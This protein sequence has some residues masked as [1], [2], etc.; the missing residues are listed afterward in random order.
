MLHT[1]AH[2]QATYTLPLLFIQASKYWFL[3]NAPVLASDKDIRDILDHLMVMIQ[4]RKSLEELESSKTVDALEM[5]IDAVVND[6][7]IYVRA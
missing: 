2:F 3:P 4:K 7:C 6:S 1:I 5:L